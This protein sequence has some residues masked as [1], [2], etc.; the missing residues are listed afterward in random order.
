MPEAIE[1]VEQYAIEYDAWCERNPAA[2]EAELRAIRLLCRPVVPVSKLGWARPI[3]RS[4][5]HPY[6][7]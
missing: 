1:A 4:A 6:G 5:G 2:Y 3:C 7:H